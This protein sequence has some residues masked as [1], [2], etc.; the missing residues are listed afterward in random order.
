MGTQ[1]LQAHLE[2]VLRQACEA[3]STEQASSLCQAVGDAAVLLAALPPLVHASQLQVLPTQPHA[4]ARLSQS[5]CGWCLVCARHPTIQHGCCR[6]WCLRSGSAG[7]QAPQLPRLPR[8]STRRQLQL[9][10]QSG[11][12]QAA[13]QLQACSASTGCTRRPTASRRHRRP[14]QVPQ[15]AAL[16][17]NDCRHLA[18]W[19]EQAP[20]RHEPTLSAALGFKPVWLQPVAQL[21]AAAQAAL[22]SVVRAALPGSPARAIAAAGPPS[23]A[24]PLLAAGSIV[25]CCRR[26]GPGCADSA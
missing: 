4:R 26:K 20:Y 19:L 25:G 24:A 13:S 12:S 10:A 6:R 7:A 8:I 3:G 22:D 15:L 9:H 1:Q 16:L 14:V 23:A 11:L 5:G 21:H 2:V 18:A 17:H